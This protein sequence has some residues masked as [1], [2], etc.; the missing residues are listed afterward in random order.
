[1][2][3]DLV[4]FDAHIHVDNR[5]KANDPRP[6][7]VRDLLAVL[8]GAGAD[9]RFLLSCD[10]PWPG[11]MR[12]DSGAIEAGNQLIHELCRQAPGQLYGSCT[13]NP[14]HLDESLRVMDLCFG[15]WGFI[16]LGEMLQYIMNYRM[17]SPESERLV[18]QAV[19]FDVPVQVHI[20]TSNGAQGEW[21]G[22]VEQL[23]DLFGCAQRVPEAKYVLA[24]AVGMPDADPPV[25]DTYLDR[26]ERE[27]GAWP[28]NFWVEIRDFNSP[29]VAS[30]L[31]RVPISRLIV[32]TDWTTRVGPPFLPYGTIFNVRRAEDNP[33]PPSVPALVDLLRG[34]GASDEQ[35]HQIGSTNAAELYRFE[36]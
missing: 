15:Q 14:H 21:S 10:L 11:R 36:V 6:N 33:Y 25:V 12:D 2:M 26:I 20:S 29:G 13:V 1:M 4:W 5:G 27:Y 22:G 32:G 19:E 34:F 23:E 28:E 17:D 30:A 31:A 7:M 8:D 18:R 16:Q 24:H 3:D 35:I 9:L